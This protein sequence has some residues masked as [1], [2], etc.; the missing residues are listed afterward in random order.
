MHGMLN[1]VILQ[2]L[3]TSG[4]QTSY[5]CQRDFSFYLRHTTKNLFYII[6]FPLSAD[7]LVGLGFFLM[8]WRIKKHFTGKNQSHTQDPGNQMKSWICSWLSYS[9]GSSVQL[10]LLFFFLFMWDWPW[11]ATNSPWY[12]KESHKIWFSFFLNIWNSYRKSQK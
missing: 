10:Q 7:I 11:S 9:S 5:S 1:T 3:F 4:L 12:W 2:I 6:R 8:V